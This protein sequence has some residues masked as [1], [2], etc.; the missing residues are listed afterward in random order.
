MLKKAF[1]DYRNLKDTHSP[2][3]ATF[4]NRQQEIQKQLQE[5]T[6]KKGKETI[7]PYDQKLAEMIA[8]EKAK[9]RAYE[10]SHGNSGNFFKDFKY[11]LKY[12]S[13]HFIKPIT[14]HAA[15]VISMLGPVGAAVGTSMTAVSGVIDKLV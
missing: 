5:E 3:Y 8:Y 6:Y 15:P 11:G 7:S 9:V 4:W 12:G 10:R 2:E 1:V 13:N 14:K